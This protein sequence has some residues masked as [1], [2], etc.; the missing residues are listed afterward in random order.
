[1]GGGGALAGAGLGLL[2]SYAV[3]RLAPP[4][5]PVCSAEL[6]VLIAAMLGGLVAGAV[7]G[8]VLHRYARPVAIWLLASSGGWLGSTLSV[9]CRAPMFD[10]CPHPILVLLSGGLLGVL[11]GGAQWYLLRRQ[12]PHALWWIGIKAVIGLGTTIT[13][14]IIMR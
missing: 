7:E 14:Q 6:W 8:A 13:L 1:M 5:F 2:N 4:L 9:W 11:T 12:L 3:V 10:Q